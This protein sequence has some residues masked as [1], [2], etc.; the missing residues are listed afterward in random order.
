MVSLFCQ[1]NGDPGP[2]PGCTCD[3]CLWLTTLERDVREEAVPTMPVS[4]GGVV[5]HGRGG[6]GAKQGLTLGYKP[7]ILEKP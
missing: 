3:S 7:D 5:V 1:R 6:R 4:A 2:V